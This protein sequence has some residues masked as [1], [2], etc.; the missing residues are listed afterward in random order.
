MSEQE[1]AP[2]YAPLERHQP[3]Q[4]EPVTVEQQQDRIDSLTATYR[5]LWFDLNVVNSMRDQ[6]E[7]QARAIHAKQRQL[8]NQIATAHAEL[9]GSRK[10]S[11]R[12]ARADIRR[13]DAAADE[14]ERVITRQRL[15][16]EAGDRHAP[17]Q[18]AADDLPPRFVSGGLP[19]TK[20]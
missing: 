17:A 6:L 16:D 14:S 8:A 9:A 19:G 4:A 18:R 11:A 13:A 20:R 7:E 5:E 12:E 1:R 2:L 15:S 3:L 10:R